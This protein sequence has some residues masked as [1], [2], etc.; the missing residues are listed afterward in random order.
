MLHPPHLPG[1][2]ADFNAARVDGRARQD[3]LDDPLGH[4]PG[5]LVMFL[6]DDDRQARTNVPAGRAVRLWFIHRRVT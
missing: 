2:Q 6:D 5:T 4:F 1:R 3:F